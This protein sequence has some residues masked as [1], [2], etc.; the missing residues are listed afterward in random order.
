MALLFCFM[1][2]YKS[3]GR[4]NCKMKCSQMSCFLNQSGN[5]ENRIERQKWTVNF[6]ALVKRVEACLS[7]VYM[8]SAD[9]FLTIE[10]ASSVMGWLWACFSQHI[11]LLKFLAKTKH[12]QSGSTKIISWSYVDKWYTRFHTFDQNHVFLLGPFL[13]WFYRNIRSFKSSVQFFVLFTI[14]VSLW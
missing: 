12:R 7:L 2:V 9:E 6:N 1:L 11:C 10:V 3:K 13:S 5:E 4:W 14:H 8:A